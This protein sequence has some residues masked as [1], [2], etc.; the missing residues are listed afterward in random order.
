MRDRLAK[1]LNLQVQSK[2]DSD[3]Q[4]VKDFNKWRRSISR[5]G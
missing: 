5:E 3:H 1:A 2:T 4:V